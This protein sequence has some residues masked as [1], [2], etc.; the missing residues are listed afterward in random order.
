MEK[1]IGKNVSSGAEKVETLE[2]ETA[3]KSATGGQKTKKERGGKVCRAQE[4]PRRRADGARQGGG[5]RRRGG[6]LRGGKGARRKKGSGA[7]AAG[8]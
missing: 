3:K 8:E 1:K 2:K 6:A 7:H 4:G 5:K